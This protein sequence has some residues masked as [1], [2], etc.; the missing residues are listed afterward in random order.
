MALAKFTKDPYFRTKFVKSAGLNI[1]GSCPVR[2]TSAQN[3]LCGIAGG[4]LQVGTKRTH[5]DANSPLV[6]KHHQNWRL[7]TFEKMPLQ[8]AEDLFFTF[9]MSLSADDAKNIRQY[10]PSVIEQIHK[11]VGPSPSEVV[12]CLNIDFFEY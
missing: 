2:A 11:I 6:A 10:L 8:R 5:I 3:G 12:R 7:R 9:P 1:F 4:K